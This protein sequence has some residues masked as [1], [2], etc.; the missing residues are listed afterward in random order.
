M[1][2]AVIQ[3]RLTVR[4][5]GV[6]ENIVFVTHESLRTLNPVMLYKLPARL[7]RVPYRPVAYFACALTA[8]PCSRLRSATNLCA[9]LIQAQFKW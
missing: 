5:E 2:L 4:C 7:A 8:L 6:L 9:Q 3:C 1:L